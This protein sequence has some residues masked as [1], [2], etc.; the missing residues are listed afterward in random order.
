M[1]KMP[2]E[3]KAK[4]RQLQKAIFKVSKIQFEID[5]LLKK[6]DLDVELFIA[7]AGL[8]MDEQTE[9][10]SYI[11]NNECNDITVEETIEEI[12]RIFLLHI[13]RREG[14]E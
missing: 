6:Y 9:G 4:L 1:D 14:N 3:M 7:E 2:Y 5:E 8:E 12:E 10:L 13:N 11:L